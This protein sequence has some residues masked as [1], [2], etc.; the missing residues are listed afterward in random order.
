MDDNNIDDSITGVLVASCLHE[1]QPRTHNIS[2]TNTTLLPRLRLAR[3]SQKTV[4]FLE[5][6]CTEGFPVWCH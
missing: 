1:L 5:A 3:R 4:S 6:Y 2:R